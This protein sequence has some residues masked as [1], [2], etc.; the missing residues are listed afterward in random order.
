MSAPKHHPLES[1]EAR[2]IRL[3]RELRI[4]GRPQLQTQIVLLI[5]L[6]TGWTQDMIEQCLSMAED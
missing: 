1:E 2:M 3:I 4:G 5:E 6:T